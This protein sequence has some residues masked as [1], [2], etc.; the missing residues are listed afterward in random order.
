MKASKLA[1]RIRRTKEKIPLHKPLVGLLRLLILQQSKD[2]ESRL[3]A[4]NM[5]SAL[6]PRPSYSPTLLLYESALAL[7]WPA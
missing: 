7:I 3:R 2:R 1:I 5:I 6:N 4:D